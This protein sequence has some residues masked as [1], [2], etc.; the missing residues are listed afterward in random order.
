VFVPRTSST[1]VATWLSQTEGRSVER[2]ILGVRLLMDKR[3]IHL[4]FAIVRTYTFFT[5]GFPRFFSIRRA[6]GLQVFDLPL[7]T[8][9]SNPNY[10]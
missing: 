5:T 3:R 4:R 7:L 2:V 8:S 10:D 1:S 9:Y 6:R